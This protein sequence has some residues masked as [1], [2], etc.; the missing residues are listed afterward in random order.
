MLDIR[1]TPEEIA[2]A[3]LEEADGSGAEEPTL[4]SLI[5][6]PATAVSIAYLKLTYAN[7]VYVM[8]WSASGGGSYDWVGLFSSVYKPD[9]EYVTYQWAS[10][11]PSYT[12][13]QAVISGYQAR[14]LVWSA[15]SSKYVSVARS[16]PFPYIRMCS[17]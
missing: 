16:D 2:A 15:A 13:S 17:T 14:Y 11:G 1:R 12:T 8:Q 5:H 3:L 7:G 10:S 4:D 9:T 6:G